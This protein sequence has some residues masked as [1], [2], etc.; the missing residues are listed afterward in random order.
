MKT[1]LRLGAV[2]TGAA[3]ALGSVT[4]AYAATPGPTTSTSATATA[5]AAKAKT[6]AARA[7]AL[8]AA[9]KLA[10]ARIEGRLGTLHALSLAVQ[11]SK[12]LTS[13]EQSTLGKQITSDVSGLTALDTKVAA[14]T[15]VQAVRTDEN[16]MIDDYRVYLLMAPQTRLT[17]AL[18]AESDAGTTLQKAYVALSDLLAKQSGGGTS[19]QRSEL[20]GLQSEITAAQAAIGNEVAAELAIQPG[21]DASAITSALTPAESAVKTARAD[22]LTARSDAK[23]LRASL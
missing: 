23:A 20:A 13:D 8:A 12:Y 21:P 15:T 17:E 22:L 6:A 2:A 7:A 14:E 18:A 1:A 19:T 3:L 9:Q 5:P 16:S 10:T 11:N 4:S